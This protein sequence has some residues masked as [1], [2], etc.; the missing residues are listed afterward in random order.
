MAA[1]QPQALYRLEAGGVAVVTLSYPPLNA[2]HPQ[3]EHWA[4]RSAGLVWGR[5]PTAAGGGVGPAGSSML[6]AHATT[7]PMAMGRC[8]VQP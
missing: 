1:A 6:A 3:R 5:P 8:H 7:P 4:W 2:L